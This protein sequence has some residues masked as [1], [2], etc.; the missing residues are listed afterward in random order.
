MRKHQLP[1]EDKTRLCANCSHAEFAHTG[2][3]AVSHDAQ[4]VGRGIADPMTACDLCMC[5]AFIGTV[6]RGDMKPDIK[7]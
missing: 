4:G 1:D 7:R 5:K 6:V 3:L 2:Q